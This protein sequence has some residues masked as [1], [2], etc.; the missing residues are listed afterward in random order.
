MQIQVPCEK[1]SPRLKLTEPTT[2]E[3]EGKGTWF[4]W[5][6]MGIGF[7]FGFVSTISAM[8]VSG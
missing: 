4:S 8:Y 6:M 3:C 2:Q 1:E 5:K 7:P